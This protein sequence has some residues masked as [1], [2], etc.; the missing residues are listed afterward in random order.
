M[1]SSCLLLLVVIRIRSQAV[2]VKQWH[3]EVGS[4]PS[5]LSS[6]KRQETSLQLPVSGL[7][8]YL[9][10]LDVLSALADAM[11]QVCPRDG[12]Q[13]NGKHCFHLLSSTPFI[14][15]SFT[16]QNIYTTMAHYAPTMPL[17]GKIYGSNFVDDDLYT[18]HETRCHKVS[19]STYSDSG[20]V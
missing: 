3:C 1:I 8:S 12:Q 10:L 20:A 2:I 13:N 18:L 4:Y 16:K 17:S 7:R 9:L 5:L 19:P 6:G 14:F 11:E 15:C